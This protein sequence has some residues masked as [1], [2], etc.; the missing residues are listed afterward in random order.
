[1]NGEHSEHKERWVTIGHAENG[2]T[3]VVVHTFAALNPAEVKLRIISAR[4]ADR[5]ETKDYEESPR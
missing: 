3:L 5:Q 4:R 1:M 2:Q